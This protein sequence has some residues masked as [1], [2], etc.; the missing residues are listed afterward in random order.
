MSAMA[1]DAL[2]EKEI[3]SLK[4]LFRLRSDPLVRVE[5]SA[6]PCELARGLLAG[7]EAD[8]CS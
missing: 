6:A 1:S 5:F 8:R 7:S 2:N 3:E 4:A